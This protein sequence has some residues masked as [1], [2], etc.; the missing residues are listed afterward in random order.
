MSQ[1]RAVPQRLFYDTFKSRFP[2]SAIGL[3]FVGIS[4]FILFPLVASLNNNKEPYEKYDNALIKEKGTDLAARITD[5]TTE[6]N[7]TINNHLHPQIITYQFTDNG[8]LKTDHFKTLPNDPTA[9]P[10]TG[11]SVGIRYYH[12]QSVIKNLASFTFPFQLFYILPAIFLLVGIPFLLVGLIPS[13][14]NYNLYKNGIEAQGTIIAITATS[15][16]ITK[17][18]S[19]IKQNVLVNYY[20]YSSH[21]HKLLGETLSNDL[22]LLSEKKANDDIKIFISPKDETVSCIVPRALY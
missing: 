19:G 8:Q 11:E 22:L 17:S 2:F 10:K 12:N 1:T 4:V 9:T 3:A 5:V 16:R 6:Y 21:G 15:T 20:Y 18:Y 13:I 14:R 7:V